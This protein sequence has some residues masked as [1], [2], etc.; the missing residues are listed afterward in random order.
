MT[1]SRV[2]KRLSILICCGLAAA[3]IPL[4]L[5]ALRMALFVHQPGSED[6]QSKR[7]IIKPGTGASEIARMLED[8]HLTA[9]ARKFYLYC[10]YTKAD[11][12]LQ[13]GEY[14]L[15]GYFTPKEIVDWLGTGRV[16]TRRLT[17]PEGSTVWE[18]ARILDEAGAA[19]EEEVLRLVKDETFIRSLNLNVPSLEGYLFPD[20]YFFSRSRGAHRVLRA[21]VR[22][23]WRNYPM[24]WE[25]RAGDRGL[26]LHQ[27]VT[28]ASMVEKEAVM[29]EE[30]PLIAAVFFNRLKKGMRLQSDPT[31]VYQL[32]DFD[33]PITRDHLRQDNPYNTY[34]RKG[35][36]IGPICSPGAKA[37]E[38]VLY[39]AE[40]SYLYFVSKNNGTHHF[41]RTYAEHRRAINLYR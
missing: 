20:T 19:K 14:E 12:R 34:T 6:W 7:I 28:M 36:P 29:D 35:L 31:A 1:W 8:Q 30:K 27:V 5:T 22:Q 10:R 11:K 38:A 41:S 2:M 21:M 3:A 9:N 17:V 4:G 39:P 32:A 24:D 33:G 26:S 25:R 23:F 40:T 13:A 37:M 15:A 16:V 18:V